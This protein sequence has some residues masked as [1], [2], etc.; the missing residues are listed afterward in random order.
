VRA[1]LQKGCKIVVSLRL[2]VGNGGGRWLGFSDE[3][4]GGLTVRH[5]QTAVG[6]V[7]RS[8]LWMPGYGPVCQLMIIVH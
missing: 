8:V 7:L 5:L 2:L 6:L 1:L 4:D 3:I